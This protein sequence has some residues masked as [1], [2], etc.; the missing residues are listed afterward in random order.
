MIPNKQKP[1]EESNSL[2]SSIID[3]LGGLEA[4]LISSNFLY[5][6]GIRYIK[7][8]KI[9]KVASCFR[10]S[11]PAL[12]VGIKISCG[13]KNYLIN[14]KMKST[15]DQRKYVFAK[16][17]NYSLKH[18]ESE[19]S[20]VRGSPMSDEQ[21][22][23]LCSNPKTSLFTIKGLYKN[24]GEKIKSLS[25]DVKEIYIL[26]EKSNKKMIIS[27]NFHL[28]NTE[29]KMYLRYWEIH[30]F[31]SGSIYEDLKSLMDAISTEH[32]KSFD[33]KNNIIE[34][35]VRGITATPRTKQTIKI[36]QFNVD[37]FVKEIQTSL[38]LGIPR[39][40]VFESLPGCGK[41]S[42][43][44]ALEDRLRNVNIM[45]FNSSTFAE[46][47]LM[48]SVTFIQDIS[49][50]IV[51]FDD[52]DSIGLEKKNSLVRIFIEVLER[53]REMKCIVISAVNDTS[54]VHYTI[55]DRPGRTD[56]AYFLNPPQNTEEVC[57]AL[58]N[59]FPRKEISQLSH[60]YLDKIYE[61]KFTYA[62]IKELATRVKL[63][64]KPLSNNTINTAIELRIQSKEAIK[65]GN[66]SKKDEDEPQGIPFT[67]NRRI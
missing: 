33:L 5:S 19:T 46:F 57:D 31:S 7:N 3:E 2:L 1:I 25:E 13:I 65:K 39:S 22:L 67:P 63:M 15:S 35:S 60:I 55:I 24:D 26:V 50:C 61:N 27:L 12:S 29:K 32:I 34:A 9:R 45:K 11:I 59:Y 43:M 28:Y 58:S 48:S 41:T 51:F 6:H 56:H 23:W 17:L 42:I 53:M 14:K 64:E 62:D 66:F 18:I 21:A 52:I 30:A 16:I 54:M 38:K 36:T 49:P 37:I 44:R 10:F 20:S 47:D 8:K 40:Y 4:V